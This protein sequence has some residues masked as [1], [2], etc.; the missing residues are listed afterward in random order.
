MAHGPLRGAKHGIVHGIKHGSLTLGGGPTGPTIYTDKGSYTSAETVQVTWSGASTSTDW[1]NPVPQG[2]G[3]IPGS[4]WVYCNS[5]T[6]SPGGA[7][8]AAGTR[9]FGPFSPGTYVVRLMFNDTFTITVE[10][11]AFTVS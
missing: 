3:A 8:Q 2:S 1:L 11:A 6:Q 4:L 7:V 10:S 5:G 9:S